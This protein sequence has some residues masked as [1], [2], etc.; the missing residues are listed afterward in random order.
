MEEK[1]KFS[2][3]IKTCLEFNA[4]PTPENEEKV[5]NLNNSLQVKEYMK[6]EDK[7]ILAARILASVPE[8]FE[9]VSNSIYLEQQKVLTGLLSYVTNME[10]DIHAQMLH[11]GSYDVLFQ[12]GFI[13]TVLKY[14]EKDYIRFEKLIDQMV[15]RSTIYK[16][17]ESAEFFN[18][19]TY[20]K[21]TKEMQNLKSELTPELIDALKAVQNYNPDEAQELKEALS[22][23]AIKQAN[24]SI[25]EGQKIK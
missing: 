14:C 7:M 4:N 21:C 8:K 1:I 25:A 11:F 16:L 12:Y 9:V 18:P 3:Y 10:D 15:N 23:E 24:I 6:I 20:D 2:D 13:D 17:I 5:K 19:E 22:Q